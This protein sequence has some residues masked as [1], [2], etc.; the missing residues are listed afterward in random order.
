MKL[1]KLSKTPTAV[2]VCRF[3]GPMS[4]LH[5][6][7]DESGD[8]NFAP[9]GSKFYIFTATWTY[10][11]VPLAHNLHAL[12]FSLIKA[13]RGSSLSRFHACED[14][15][16]HRDKVV[17]MLSSHHF[18][19][20]AGIVVEKS[21]VNPVI[22]GP[23]HF[24]PKFLMMLL[25]F[26]LRGNVRPDT[27]KILIY[28]DTLPEGIGNR[29]ER[30]AVSDTIAKVCAAERPLI[31]L[32]LMHHSSHSNAW[33]QVTD[34]CSWSLCRKWENG[35]VRTYDKLRAK[36]AVPELDPMSKGTRRYY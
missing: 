4:T 25:R 3:R 23:D 12:R 11:P 18:W 35:D 15:Q 10:H 33:L 2:G 32:H 29:K 34:Y 36:M 30:K 1:M 9:K 31:P 28:T 13:G 7:V 24:Y 5:I 17:E 6:H 20:F 8:L 27:S 22:Q 26:I 21:K 16:E 19:W 14:A